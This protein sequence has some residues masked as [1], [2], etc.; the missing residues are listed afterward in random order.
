MSKMKLRKFYYFCSSSFYFGHRSL[1][2]HQE[3]TLICCQIGQY[4][5]LLSCILF[6]DQIVTSRD[7]VR[8]RRR[9]M[10]I[11]HQQ[12]STNHLILIKMRVIQDIINYPTLDMAICFE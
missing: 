2:V 11:Y 1:S 12:R 3:H 4:N 9:Y 10:L 6:D 5:I 7:S 8:G